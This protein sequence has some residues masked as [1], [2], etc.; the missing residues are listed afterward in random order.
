MSQGAGALEPQRSSHR[1]R[2]RL[3]R[4]SDLHVDW[5]VARMRLGHL[6]PRASPLASALSFNLTVGLGGESLPGLRGRTD[7]ASRSWQVH[8]LLRAQRKSQRPFASSR[9]F[10]FALQESSTTRPLGVAPPRARSLTSVSL[11]TPSPH[12]EGKEARAGAVSSRQRFVR[13]GRPCSPC[14]GHTSWH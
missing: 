4:F 13:S 14:A 10:S 12:W 3:C 7:L 2:M 5:P 6:M 1:W 11:A 9:L 8:S